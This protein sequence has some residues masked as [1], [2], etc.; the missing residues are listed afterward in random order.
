[1]RVLCTI[2]TELFDGNCDVSAVPCGHTFHA[3][4]LL[5]WLETSLTCPQCRTR[6]TRKAVV[7][8]LY[9]SQPDAP[10]DGG[11][12]P[13]PNELVNQLETAKLSLRQ[14]DGDLS[15]MLAEKLSVE[16]RLIQSNQNIRDLEK[17]HK[18]EVAKSKLLKQQLVNYKDMQHRTSLA[19][20]EAE[21]LRKK[22]AR[23]QSVEKVING[24][25]DDIENMITQCDSPSQLA[26]WC[27]V[28]KRELDRKKAESRDLKESNRKLKKELETSKSLLA[29]RNVELANC[30]EKEEKARNIEESQEQ[31]IASLRKKVEALQAAIAS[32]S[33]TTSGFARRLINESPAPSFSPGDRPTLSRPPAIDLDEPPDLFGAVLRE[34][35]S[36]QGHTRSQTQ[37]SGK[38]RL[39]GQETEA[40]AIKISTAADKKPVEGFNAD[41]I[42]NFMQLN[43]LRNRQSSFL[44]S[45]SGIFR[46]G[47]NGLGGHDK[48][49]KPPPRQ[50]LLVKK[51]KNKNSFF[52]S[53][54]T[55]AVE[56]FPPL[57]TLID[58][59][60]SSDD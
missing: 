27:C 34:S 5:R 35:N 44:S 25:E 39:I 21:E 28:Y 12:E 58:D 40:K 51:N 22:L 59:N 57:P 2:C 17:L 1:M 56:S 41:G 18:E 48:F 11:T 52:R 38:R 19:K 30:K 42:S 15:R 54:S 4:C 6:V 32:P 20:Q 14:R 24:S 3:D 31:Q 37:L 26:T 29:E 23:L 33:D 46:Q 7:P 49:V 53:V 45:T 60:S 10:N 50:P 9:F 47:F 36:S 55:S 43:I 13:E 16:E 8:K